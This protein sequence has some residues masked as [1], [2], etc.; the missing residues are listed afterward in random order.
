M[1]LVQKLPIG[2][3]LAF[4]MM[5]S[6][7]SK[8]DTLQPGT[9]VTNE[10]SNLRE[11]GPVFSAYYLPSTDG[12]TCIGCAPKKWKLGD[13]ARDA[14]SSLTAYGGNPFKKWVQPLSE[15]ST[16]PGSIL[17]VVTDAQGSGQAS[18]DMENLI[19]GKKYKLTFS[20]STTSIQEA[21]RASHFASHAYLSVKDN[22]TTPYVNKYVIINLDKTNQWIT[23]TIEFEAKDNKQS[24]NLLTYNLLTEAN[25]TYTNFHVGPDAVQQIN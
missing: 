4:L 15:P 14:T 19:K 17:T 21:G 8:E 24:V 13:P 9:V 2:L 3:G 23:K 22:A 12:P 18:A 10:S 1:N 5:M 7:C 20:I 16:G 11:G 6:S 25:L